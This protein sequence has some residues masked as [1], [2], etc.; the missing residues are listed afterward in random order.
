[1]KNIIAF[2]LFDLKSLVGDGGGW[3]GVFFFPFLDHLNSCSNAG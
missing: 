3:V 1:M 2:L